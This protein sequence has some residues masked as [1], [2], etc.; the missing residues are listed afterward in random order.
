MKKRIW[1]L[2]VFMVVAGYLYSQCNIDILKPTKD[3]TICAGDS[4][5]IVADGSCTFLMNN[6]FDNGSIGVGWSSTGA[7][8]VFTNP[9]GIGPDSVYL[10]VG[11]TP[12]N[13]RSL[14]THDYDVSTTNCVVKWYM[15]YGAQTGSGACE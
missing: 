2:A 5:Q 7:N 11:T 14:E 8:P 10:W 4:V 1:L 6:T 9:C 15:R 13:T 3:T 12:S